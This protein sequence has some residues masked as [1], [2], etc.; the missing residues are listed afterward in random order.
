MVR[1]DETI[2]NRQ[3]QQ[4]DLQDLS[5]RGRLMVS[6]RNFMLGSIHSHN[7]NDIEFGAST[8]QYRLQ[9]VAVRNLLFSREVISVCRNLRFT[10]LYSLAHERSLQPNTQSHWLLRKLGLSGAKA[11][12]YE[13]TGSAQHSGAA[14]CCTF[15]GLTPNNLVIKYLHW[16]FRSSFMAVFLSAAIAFITLTMIFALFI[17]ALGRANPSCIGGLE[18]SSDYFT[19]AYA[20]SWTTFSTVVSVVFVVVY[21][22]G[23]LCASVPANVAN[24][25]NTDISGLM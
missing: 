3:Q 6:S 21:L 17:W 12:I 9:A 14:P 13:D 22:F 15:F 11:S 5:M 19:D 8:R 2:T 18:D 1:K 7:P 10:H 23:R 24:I 4:D 25:I 20:L 16:T